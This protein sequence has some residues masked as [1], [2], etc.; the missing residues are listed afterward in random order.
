MFDSLEQKLIKVTNTSEKSALLQDRKE[1]S[2]TTTSQEAP[3]LKEA[4]P[5]T[6]TKDTETK[7]Y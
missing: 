3:F 1:A 2:E 5:A 4:L 6:T 7:R